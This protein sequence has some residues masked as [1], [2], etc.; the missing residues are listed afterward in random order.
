MHQSEEDFLVLTAQ[1]GDRRAIDV[2]YRQYYQRLFRYAYKVCGTRDMAQEA[3][4]EAW[5]RA[6]KTLNKLEDPRAFRS[7]LYNLVRWRAIDLL[8]AASR[9]GEDLEASVHEATAMPDDAADD[10]DELRRAINRL[11]LVERQIIHLFYLDELQV[12]EIALVLN[13]ANG[14]VKS[15]LSRARKLL[16]ERFDIN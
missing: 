12:K 8:R 4:Q 11:P 9:N 13:V 1:G 16:K 10:A 6:M 5:V 15:R 2:L 3:V 14:T 7:W